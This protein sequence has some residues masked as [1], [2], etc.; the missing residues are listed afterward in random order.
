[1]KKPEPCEKGSGVFMLWKNSP[2]PS[3]RNRLE[4][5]NSLTSFHILSNGFA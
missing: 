5:T 1:M 3:E 4:E 2:S